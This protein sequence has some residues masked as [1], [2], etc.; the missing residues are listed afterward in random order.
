MKRCVL[1]FLFS[2]CAAALRADLVWDRSYGWRPTS[3]VFLEFNGAPKEVLQ[4]MN[5][6]RL[7]QEEDRIGD[8][9]SNYSRVCKHFPDT[10]FA[11]EAYYQ[12][13]KIKVSRRQFNDAFEAFNAIAKKYP[14]YPR[15]N[16]V[17]REEFEIAR[18][19]K[20][21]ERPKYFGVIPGF[22]DYRATFNF[23]KKVVDDAPFSDIAPLALS[24]MAELAASKNEPADTIASLERLIDSYPYSEYT[25]WA[26]FKLGEIY[27]KMAKSPL[28]DQGA[29]KLAMGYYED[30]LALYPDDE[31]AEEAQLAY[32]AMK[33]R[34]ARSKLLLG[35]FYFNARNNVRAAVIMYRKA[36]RE[37]PDSA[38]ADEAAEKINYIRNGGLPRKTPVDFLFGRYRRPSG[39][40]VDGDD[41]SVLAESAADD[42]FDLGTDFIRIRSSDPKD[43][44]KFTD[45]DD[46]GPDEV[47]LEV[48]PSVKF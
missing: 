9:L 11:P 20:S 42:G 2:L 27:S 3:D 29:T 14:K 46:P 40:C 33:V 22:R 47:F 43:G 37:L 31:R 26:Y 12:T 34:L 5:D 17:L 39:E 38:V 23:Y 48:G 1:V 41:G 32:E 6:A 18:L 15:F 28:Y 36:A 13:G 10:V 7:A 8:A 30:F 45:P 35:D 21:G 16:N 25:P 44:K 4:L 24:H 19:L